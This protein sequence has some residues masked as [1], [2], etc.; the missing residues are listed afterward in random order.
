MQAR[1]LSRELALLSL[2]QLPKNPDKLSEQ[3]LNDLILA[4][5]RT[6]TLEAHEALETAA[7]ELKRG[8][9][10]L[11]TS[12]VR[13]TDLKS[14]KASLVDAMELT[15]E[16]IERLGMAVELPEFLQLANQQEVRQYALEL[17]VQVVR[18]RQEIDELLDRTIVDW[19]L[20]RLPRVERDILRLATTEIWQIGTPERVVVDEAVELTKRYSSDN[21][22]RFVN[23]V[24]R[25]VV[26]ALGRSDN[27]I[28]SSNPS[29][30]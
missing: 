2:S 1:S 22:H 6:M 24:L 16:A 9:D 14:A 3:D 11:T 17:I 18:N 8:N 10:R 5:V 20:D 13:D 15:R 29:A 19:Q 25:R 4:A 30:L 26:E 23:G 28:A 27:A 7:A 21:A 12:E